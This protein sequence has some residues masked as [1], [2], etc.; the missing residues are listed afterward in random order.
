[1]GLQVAECVGGTAAIPKP[2]PHPGS[3]T[4]TGSRREAGTPQPAPIRPTAGLK[5]DKNR[6]AAGSH[7]WG[8]CHERDGQLC[9]RLA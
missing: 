9:S 5:Q 2:W 3:T 8:R 1:M 6:L 7:A 4:A